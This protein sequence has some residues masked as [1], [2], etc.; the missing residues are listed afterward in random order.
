MIP[1][2]RKE[3][4]TAHE[5]DAAFPCDLIIPRCIMKHRILALIIAV[6]MLTACF[7]TVT[8]DRPADGSA[9]GIRVSAGTSAEAAKPKPKKVKITGSKY[10]AKGKKITI[11]VTGPD[12]A[13]SSFTGR[14]DDEFLYDAIGDIDGVTIDGY[15]SDW[16]YYITTVNG[17]EAN[18][19]TDGAY[20]SLYV[21][22]EY[23][24]NGVSTQPVT[25]GDVYGFVYE[26]YEAAE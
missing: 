21:N 6:V 16:G 10:V 3:A 5:G 20:W 1:K 15:D 19:D 9:P 22:G 23:G 12:G 4:D 14:T 17:I 13:T 18:Y 25:E 24:Q 2:K 8:V 11:E 7:P 26:V